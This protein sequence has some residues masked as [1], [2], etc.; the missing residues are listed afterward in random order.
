MTVTFVPHEVHIAMKKGWTRA[1]QP[2]IP[3]TAEQLERLSKMIRK[4][5]I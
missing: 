5:V 1:H 3:L 2:R 4:K